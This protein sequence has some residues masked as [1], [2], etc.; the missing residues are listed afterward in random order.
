MR[1]TLVFLSMLFFQISFSQKSIT[2]TAYGPLTIKEFDHGLAK[3]ENGKTDTLSSS[4]SG[5]HNWLEDFKIIS[6]TDSIQAQPKANFG[7]VYIINA[8]ESVD[9]DVV[10]EW[11]YP[12]EVTNAKGKK[13]KSFTY[14][15]KRP[16]NTVT[17]SSYSLDEPYELVKG[18]WQLNVYIEKQQVLGRTFI[19]Y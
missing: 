6:V 18:N 16:T 13:F 7:S 8:K 14:G 2:T 11:I 5:T 3:V 1:L 17:A 10:I 4:P 19:V 12:K 9:I 15:T